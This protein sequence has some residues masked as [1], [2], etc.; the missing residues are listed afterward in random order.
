MISMCGYVGGDMLGSPRT[1]FA[2]ARDGFLPAAL[3]RVHP[4][5][6]TPHL[7]IALHALLVWAAASLGSFGQLALISNVSVLSLYLLCCAGAWELV[8]RDVR[9]GGA[10]FTIPGQ[11]IVPL[12]AC[13]TVLWMLSH[14]TAAE[15]R[16]EAVVLAVASI[17]YVLRNR[18]RTA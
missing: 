4:R 5:F 14:A 15:W 2:F 18:R 17:A 10:P 16:V 1:L 11:R 12:L 13:G 8:R 7:A 9:A 6:H 3:A